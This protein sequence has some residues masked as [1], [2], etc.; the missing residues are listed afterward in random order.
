MTSFDEGLDVIEQDA[1]FLAAARTL[2][3]FTPS[4]RANLRTEGLACAVPKLGLV[5]GR[6]T[7]AGR[8]AMTCCTP[9]GA[10]GALPARRACQALR[11]A[12]LRRAR[13]QRPRDP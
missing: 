4:S 11:P 2:P 5:D 10:A 9:C 13:R 1:A 8:G 6:Q 3:R 7:A 12:R